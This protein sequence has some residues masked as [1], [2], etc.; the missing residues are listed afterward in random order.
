[1]LPLE[2]KGV[3]RVEGSGLAL[4]RAEELPLLHLDRV[5][6]RARRLG[7]GDPVVS[8]RQSTILLV[9]IDRLQKFLS[10]T[11]EGHHVPG[12]RECP[13][14]AGNRNLQATAK[15]AKDRSRKPG[16]ERFDQPGGLPQHA[17]LK[18]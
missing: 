2:I 5:E 9:P 11:D 13:L 3:G 8:A 4:R 1:L 16:E 15:T 12:P 10:R 18:I 6:L 14:P 17:D 7:D